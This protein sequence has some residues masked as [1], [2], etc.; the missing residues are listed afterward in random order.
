MTPATHLDLYQLTSLVPH[1]EAGRARTPVTMSFFSRR[2]PR[3]L[4]GTPARGYLLWTGLRRC[5]EWLAEARFEEGR[6]ES[7][8]GHPMLGP[9]L[10][11]RPGL[12]DDLRRWC[13]NGRITAPPEGT[14]LWAGRAVAPDDNSWTSTVFAHRLKRPT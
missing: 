4:D 12:V 13:F 5:L 1:W 8:L 6:I 14:P 3:T 7:L 9:A 10:D 2:L 11:A